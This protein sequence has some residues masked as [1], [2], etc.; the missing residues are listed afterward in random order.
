MLLVCILEELNAQE[1]ALEHSVVCYQDEQIGL[2]L[3]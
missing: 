2:S 3:M 1:L